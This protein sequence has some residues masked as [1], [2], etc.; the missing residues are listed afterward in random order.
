MDLS[1]RLLD[2]SHLDVSADEVQFEGQWWKWGHLLD[3]WQQIDVALNSHEIGQGSA[4]GIVLRNRPEHAAALLATV[5]SNRCA[6]TLSYLKSDT[7]LCADIEQLSLASIIASEED[8][9]RD[10]FYDSV[11]ESGALGLQLGALPGQ[12]LLRAPMATGHQSKLRT[13]IAI[14]M[15]TSG[16]TGSPK[17][18]PLSYDGLATSIE[19][20][21]HYGSSLG[22]SGIPKLRGGVT[23][24][25][26]PLAHISGSWAW[27]EAVTAGRRVALLEHFSVAGWLGLIREHQPA[28]SSLPPACVRMILDSNL[29]RDDLASLKAVRS[30]TAPLD[31]N[32]AEEF[33]DRFG[34][35]VLVS[36]GATEFAGAVAGWTLGDR[37]K[38][39]TAKRGSV[40]KAHPGIELRIIGD[41][42][43]VL[44]DDEVGRLEVRGGQL[45]SSPDGDWVGTEDLASIDKDGFLWL[46]GRR[47]DVIIRGGFKVDGVRVAAILERHPSVRAAAVVGIPN[48][49]LGAVPFAFAELREQSE[50]ITDEGII[51]WSR[52]FLAPYEVP[53][54]LVIMDQLPRT[55]T[56]K[57]S[58]GALREF[59]I[60]SGD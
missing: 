19:T 52:S 44:S 2:I 47:D 32:V 9:E 38:Y 35:P 17:R 24:I 13:G 36:Y 3:T 22:G 55:A 42:G 7:D 57:I 12:L 45:G 26:A 16:T 43:E 28:F 40:G 41:S 31:P 21:S 25:F 56:L 50:G 14:E 5:A 20:L 15:L 4:V 6:A 27:I 37:E 23:I 48:S 51:S 8:W 34:V 54:R 60:N 59:A 10:G 58:A 39:R 53:V 18:I 30:S 49:R 46:W 11:V 1:K 29:T 33:E